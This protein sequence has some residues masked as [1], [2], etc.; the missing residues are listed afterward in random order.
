MSGM[1]LRKIKEGRKKMKKV[2]MTS[3]ALAALLVAQTLF[4][5]CGNTADK[6]DSTPADSSEE[7]SDVQS[8]TNET[9][10]SE[11]TEAAEDTGST[12]HLIGDGSVTLTIFCDFQN[13]ARSYYTDLGDNP[14]V[15]WIEKDTGLNLEFIHAPANDDGTF[16]Q[17]MLLG[18][19]PDLI[20]SS[21]FQ[22]HYPGGVEG[23][24]ACFWM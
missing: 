3:I 10:D 19:L 23:A 11:E 12:S 16:F 2:K 22:T 14:V 1:C 21:R 15:Q 13:A 7:T 18:D 6:T 9:S 5:G 8:T 20:F 24:I 17:N 4:T